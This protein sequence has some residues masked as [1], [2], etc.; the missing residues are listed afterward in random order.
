MNQPA[1]FEERRST[2]E[3]GRSIDRL[4]STVE[5][6]DETVD[7]LREDTV[8]RREFDNEVRRI[9]QRIDKGDESRMWLWR[10]VV[11]GGTLTL[12]IGLLLL[13]FRSLGVGA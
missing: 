5:K 12:G 4:A 8:S 10:T 13:W 7:R 1:D 3:L 2:G 9:E 11:V 6:L